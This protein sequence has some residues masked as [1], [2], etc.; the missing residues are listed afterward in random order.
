MKRY[1]INTKAGS[2]K[3]WCAEQKNKTLLI[4]FGRT[5]TK[6]Q[7]LKKEFTNKTLCKAEADK[8]IKEKIKKGYKEAKG[9][10]AVLQS[11]G[12][13]S[14][15][16]KK[17]FW[18]LINTSLQKSNLE[19]QANY[20]VK[21]LSKLSKKDLA[22]FENIYN[23]FDNACYTWNL[24]AAAYTIHRGCSDDSF[25]DFR[26]W[27]IARGEIVYTKA[28]VSSDSL[29]ALSRKKLEQSKNGEYFLFLASKVYGDVYH[30]NIADDKNIKSF[31]IK[32]TP[33][34]REW[35]EGNIKALE[36]INP[37]LFRMF[38]NQWK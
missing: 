11:S 34:G 33:S 14:P 3:F 22:S 30:K 23:R 12:P 36:K 6:G 25:T 8:L 18:Q 4:S 31:K 26:A 10:P 28:L 13:F 27:L 21:E 32:T 1:F 7:L 38:K 35:E 9:L 16:T 15:M 37:T 5:G 29:S 2:N 24:W 20:L 19:R 17:T